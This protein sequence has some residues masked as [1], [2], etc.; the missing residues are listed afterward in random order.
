METYLEPA[1]QEQPDLEQADDFLDPN[2]LSAAENIEYEPEPGVIL[3]PRTTVN[4]VVIAVAFFLLG[5]VTAFLLYNRTTEAVIDRAIARAVQSGSVVAAAP[6]A[7]PTP[8]FYEVSEDDDPFIGAADAQVVM[9]EFSDFHCSF[10]N[11]FAQETLN[12]LIEEYGDRVRFVYRD[13]PVLHPESAPASVAAECAADQGKFW[14]YHNL[15]FANQALFGRELYLEI[16]A[17][18]ELDVDTFTECLGSSEM[19]SEVVADRITGEGLGIRGTPTFF[20]NG[21]ILVGAQ[22]YEVFARM[23]EEE[24]AQVAANGDTI[25]S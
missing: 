25:T 24:L 21:R 14:E 1:V 23:I 12:P 9:I 19:M 7:T 8:D 5:A 16:A 17:S 6:T 3:L 15:L 10:C 4:Y 22:P 2:A 18:L 20:I 11:R 13:Y